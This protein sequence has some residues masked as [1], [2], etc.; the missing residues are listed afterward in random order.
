[1]GPF[2]HVRPGS[3]IGAGARVG[4]FVELKKTDLGTGAKAP[5]LSYLGD[6]TIGAGANIGAG[7]IVANYDGARDSIWLQP[8]DGEPRRL[9][10][11]ELNPD[12]GISARAEHTM[13]VAVARAIPNTP[14]GNSSNR[15]E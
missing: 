4:N 1:M 6:T 14:R 11:G 13:L 7:T 2:S 8:L 5:H 12:Y 3:R 9:D 10:L 15:S